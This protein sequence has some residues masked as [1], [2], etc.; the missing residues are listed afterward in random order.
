MSKIQK[1]L[2][3]FVE[4]MD[5]DTAFEKYANTRYLHSENF[6][7]IDDEENSVGILSNNV[8]N[9][10][11]IKYRGTLV[12]NTTIR[13]NLILFIVNDTITSI[14]EIPIEDFE[15]KLIDLTAV[16]VVEAPIRGI[17]GDSSL[18]EISSSPYLKLARNF[19]NTESTEIK[20]VGR[21]E[22]I[23]I[24]K[25]YWIDGIS[26]KY[27]NLKDPN[28]QVNVTKKLE[29][30]P[31]NSVGNVEIIGFISGGLLAGKVQYGYQLFNINGSSTEINSLS[32]LVNITSSTS[33]PSRSFNGDLPGVPTNK[34]CHIRVSNIDTEFDRIRLYR[35]FYTD[36]TQQ[37]EVYIVEEVAINGRDAIEFEDVTSVGAGQVE[38]ERI[39][40]SRAELLFN[41]LEAKNN[42][43]F[44]GN[45]TEKV[46]DF[47]VPITT[48]RIRR[49][50]EPI[51]RRRRTN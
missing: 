7:F 29:A 49:G 42:V 8:G 10:F 20:A 30:Y 16:Q 14:F 15:N 50:D 9:T 36:L 26:F 1:H 39:N 44:V 43:L 51:T 11:K 37:P 31:E 22:S 47:N 35:I 38:S 32:S 46:F 41:T 34:G 45:V 27:C 23:N 2:V 4:G 6:R 18:V 5:K 33:G 17:V 3:T 24:E 19:G 48:T 13:N 40:T 21:Y 28:L 25:L 12:G